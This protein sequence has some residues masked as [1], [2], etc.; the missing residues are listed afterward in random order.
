MGTLAASWQQQHAPV[1]CDVGLDD[2]ARLALGRGAIGSVAGEGVE[3]DLLSDHSNGG[4][5]GEGSGGGDRVAEA[6]PDGFMNTHAEYRGP[7][8]YSIQNRMVAIRA[9]LFMNVCE[10]QVFELLFMNIT[11]FERLLE[12]TFRTC[13]N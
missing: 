4:L 3:G 1:P 13:T 6:V 10:M 2:G 7:R 11:L 5:G 8:H 9:I 12:L